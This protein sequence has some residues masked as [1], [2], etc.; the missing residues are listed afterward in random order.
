MTAPSSENLAKV[1]ES[2]GLHGMAARARLDM[3]H[4]YLAED[5]LSSM[6]LERE[7]REARD[8]CPDAER[9]VKIEEVR[10]Q[11]M[12]GAFDATTEESDEWAASP[13]GQAAFRALRD[14][15]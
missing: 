15:E 14:G 1:L 3:Y 6:T 9:R 7:L 13:E 11:H 4:D 12:A 8:A 10:Q 5:A 2:V